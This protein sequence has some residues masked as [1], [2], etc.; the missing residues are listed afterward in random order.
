MTTKIEPTVIAFDT[1]C[2]G[3]QCIQDT[4]ETGEG[5]N[6]VYHTQEELVED[7]KFFGKDCFAVPL[8][9]YKEGHKIIYNPYES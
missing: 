3:L 9:D 8:K 6:A 2:L 4:D 7:L 5:V 1:I